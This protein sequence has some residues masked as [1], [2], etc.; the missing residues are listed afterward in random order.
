MNKNEQHIKNI[1]E[2]DE[3]KL[4]ETK[5]HETEND[6]LIGESLTSLG[7]GL[8]G[9]RGN[10]EEGYSG[11]THK[12]VYNGGVWFPDKTKVGWWK[13]GY[14]EYF[15][16]AIN[17]LNFLELEI[18]IDNVKLDLFIQKPT[19]FLRELDMKNG[20]LSRK[21]T[22]LISDIKIDV[23]TERFLSIHNPE[24][25]YIKYSIKPDKDCNIEIKSILN[26]DVHNLDSNHGEMFWDSVS[27]T[28]DETNTFV[29]IKTKPNN[30][31]VERFVVAGAMNNEVN[32]KHEKKIEVKPLVGTE[33][34]KIFVKA[35]ENCTLIKK[36]AILSSRN[37]EKSKIKK[38]A[39]DKLE[40]SD[41]YEKAKELHFAK[42]NKRWENGD[43]SIEGDAKSQQGI[44]F[45]LFQLFS[46]YYGEDSKLNIGP[47]GFT[48]EKYGGATYWD[49]E[50]YCLPVYLSTAPSYVAK[51]LLLYRYDQLKQAKH[52]A[53]QQGLDGAL[54]PMVT[55]N[56]VE[57][58]NEWEITFEE[59]HRNGIMAYA[60]Y[61]YINYTGDE[62]Y[63]KT[64]GIEVLI[65]L[66]KFWASRVHYSKAKKMYMIHGVTGPNEFENNVNNNWY[67]NTISKWTLE[68]TLKSLKKLKITDEIQ[69]KKY[70][71]T[72]KDL[73][74]WEEIQKNMYLPYSEEKKIFVQHDT[75]L[76]KDMMRVDQLKAR[77]R[78]IVNNWSWDK[79][80]RSVFI[81]Q[82]DVLQGMYLFQENYTKDELKKN[83]EFYE[84]FTVHESSLSSCI[85]SILAAKLGK[86]DDAVK[87]Y[88]RAAR[89]DLDNYNDDTKD[90]LHITS[91]AGSW[92][93]IIEGFGGMRVIDGILNFSPTIPKIWKSL[94]FNIL[95]RKN[96]IK[97]QIT[98]KEIKITN[99]K[100][101]NI[102]IK[103][104][105][106]DVLLEKTF[107]KII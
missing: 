1:F 20:I 91:M 84:Q 71:L 85:H 48:G 12:G 32:I 74:K 86:I 10:F 98:N 102:K 8:M 43:I 42:W 78:P 15:G 11:K 19:S 105:N 5:I 66:S 27:S 34:L 63:L 62:E 54:F 88:L 24:M 29:A 39:L 94:S 9:S 23:Y 59:I 53:R 52:N 7:N 61:N 67:T 51:N 90:G 37:H 56:G 68:Y 99:T 40:K 103:L 3:W 81:K 50:A 92:M 80:L 33:I 4:I 69:L 21:F 6:F 95:F 36:I 49:T 64:N 75:F 14:P 2:I 18:K 17:S 79:I 30:F 101:E 28:K 25:V 38:I 72:K 16:K 26:G 47:K 46:T 45:S 104:F 70:E 65:E 93:S 31:G 73:I 87:F 107:T 83:Y 22:T 96:L 55:F 89:L 58:H 77:D 35:N 41:D 76:D 44:R 13:N 60:I 97:M 100:G 82:A 106:E 57:C